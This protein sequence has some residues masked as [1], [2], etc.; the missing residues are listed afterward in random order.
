M[1]VNPEPEAI[2]LLEKYRLVQNYSIY[3]ILSLDLR[4]IGEVHQIL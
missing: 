3:T 4:S 1:G 2:E